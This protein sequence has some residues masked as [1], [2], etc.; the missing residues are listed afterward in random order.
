MPALRQTSATAEPS[1]ACFKTNAICA[2]ENFDAFMELSSSP[3]GDHK[4]K[5]PV[6]TGLIWR[7]HVTLEKSRHRSLSGQT[8]RARRFSLLRFSNGQESRDPP[9]DGAGLKQ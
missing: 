8:P 9:R 6:Q 3:S 2:S 1:S 4:W 7:G 5:I